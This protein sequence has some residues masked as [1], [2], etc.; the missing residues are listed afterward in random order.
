MFAD[1]VADKI[2]KNLGELIGG[3]SADRMMKRYAEMSKNS[4]KKY[5]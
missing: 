3:D 4:K 5:V 1:F 2:L